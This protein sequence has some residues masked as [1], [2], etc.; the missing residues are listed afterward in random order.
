MRLFTAFLFFSTLS[1]K[2][3]AQCSSGI[4]VGFTNPSFEGPTGS[5]ITPEPWS[6]CGNTPDTQPGFWGVTQTPSDG[7]SYLGLV[8]GSPTW[9]EGAS[10]LLVEPIVP[11]TNYAFNIDLSATD[12]TGG[13]IDS[14]AH[15]VLEV[16]GA[17]STCTQTELLWS[18]TLITQVGWQTFQV[19]FTPSSTYE[20]LSFINNGQVNGYLLVDNISAVV[21][22]IETLQ[23]LSHVDSV[24]EDCSFI[25]TGWANPTYID[26]VVVN[27][28]FV[29][30]PLTADF[31]DSTW[32]ADIQFSQFGFQDLVA[33]AYYTDNQGNASVCTTKQVTFDIQPPVASFSATSG[34]SN[35][36][37]AF[38]DSSVAAGTGQITDW[39]WDFGD[40]NVSSQQ[41]P[42]HLYGI[43]GI[44][45]VELSVT[46]SDGC[47]ADTI[48]ELTALPVPDADFTFSEVC[49]GYSSNFHDFSLPFGGPLVHWDWD[50]G[51]GNHSNAEDPVH[52][53]NTPDSF[54]VVL[55]VTDIN[56]CLDT[57]SQWVEVFVCNTNSI[58][59][60]SE[61][62]QVEFYPNPS[63]SIATLKT[64]KVM[65]QIM[66]FDNSGR[67]AIHISDISSSLEELNLSSIATGSYVARVLFE[68]STTSE[69]R[70]SV[71][72]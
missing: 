48:M 53:Y 16:W 44:Y 38:I 43:P 31:I 59:D 60:P 19:S 1:L 32:N 26:S 67:L 27:G 52:T 25:F 2:V 47:S 36:P 15:G 65:E 5:H 68:N 58:D 22:S 28:N 10:Q 18:S 34:C 21:D 63:T 61:Q 4:P 17:N 7:N 6:N 56:G 3:L 45:D 71:M 30:S 13:G 9:Q 54:K 66:V 24:T 33:V 40:G 55:T 37:I 62:V 57:L 64:S 51:D 11:G 35:L 12:A 70:I 69:F 72:K 39:S 50:F 20:Y 29:G 42:T 41:N 49:F 23:T 8:Y 46:S 14:T